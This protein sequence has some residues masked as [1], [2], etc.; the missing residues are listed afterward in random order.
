MNL[1]SNREVILRLPTSLSHE[2]QIS[3]RHDNQRH[4]RSIHYVIK[5]KRFAL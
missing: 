1:K 3:G 4:Q 5:I 2:N